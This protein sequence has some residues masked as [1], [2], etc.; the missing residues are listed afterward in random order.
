M[1][2]LKILYVNSDGFYQEHSESADSVKFLSFKTA[3][4]ELTDAK[5]RTR[6]TSTYMMRGILERTNSFRQVQV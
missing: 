1:A 4:K 5:L 3:N 2:D 6:T